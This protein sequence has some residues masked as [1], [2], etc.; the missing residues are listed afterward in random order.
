MQEQ[1]VSLIKGRLLASLLLSLGIVVCGMVWTWKIGKQSSLNYHELYHE[2]TML[3]GL[4]N[5]SAN[6]NTQGAKH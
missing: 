1:N 2:K 6:A 5:Y 4:R 3:D